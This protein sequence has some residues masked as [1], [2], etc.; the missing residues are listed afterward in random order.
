MLT[1]PCPACVSNAVW[2]PVPVKFTVIKL[3]SAPGVVLIHSLPVYTY[4]SPVVPVSNQRSPAVTP[5]LGAVV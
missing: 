3:A 5:I 4:S 2:L 1:V